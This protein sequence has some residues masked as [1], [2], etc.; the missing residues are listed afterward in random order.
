MIWIE[1]MLK[2]IPPQ[3]VIGKTSPDFLIL[4]LE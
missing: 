1:F 2:L 3:V 4:A